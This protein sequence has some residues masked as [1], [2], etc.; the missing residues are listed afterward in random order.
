MTRGDKRGQGENKES[1]PCCP[2]PQAVKRSFEHHCAFSLS[3]RSHAAL[4]LAAPQLCSSQPRSL[5]HHHVYAA[6]ATTLR[7]DVLP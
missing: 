4:Q 1:K 3:A 6:A 7:H 2:I 5:A